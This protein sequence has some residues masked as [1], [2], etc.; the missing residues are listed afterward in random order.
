MWLFTVF[1]AFHLLSE[2]RP[3][4]IDDPVAVC[5]SIAC[6][7]YKNGWT[8]RVLVWR[9][10]SWRP[11]EQCIRQGVLIS[12]VDRER[13]FDAAFV[14]LLWLLVFHCKL[15]CICDFEAFIL[16]SQ[17]FDPIQMRLVKTKI[18]PYF[19]YKNNTKYTK[20]LWRQRQTKSRQGSYA[21]QKIR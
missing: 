8:N 12:H 4:A 17:I 6:A 20:L 15:M 10:N 9:G 13:G 21:A 16:I 7:V 11:K 1:F 19:K 18:R 5:L 14:N 2:V 3:F